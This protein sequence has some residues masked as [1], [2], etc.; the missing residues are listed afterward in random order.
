VAPN[1]PDAALSDSARPT[2]SAVIAV[3]RCDCAESSADVTASTVS[4]G[5]PAVFR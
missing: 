1:A 3:L 5:A 2:T 4:D